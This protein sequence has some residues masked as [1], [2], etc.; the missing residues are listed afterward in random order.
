MGGMGDIWTDEAN[1][2]N[3]DQYVEEKGE[4]GES[5]VRE[6]WEGGARPTGAR[7]L[8]NLLQRARVF[9]GEEFCEAV[10]ED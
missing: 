7:V 9:G 6:V 4:N 2:T 3:G 8:E 1:R 10:E 5:E